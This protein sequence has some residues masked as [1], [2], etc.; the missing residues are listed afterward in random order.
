MCVEDEQ[1]GLTTSRP[2]W[3]SL[4]PQGSVCPSPT[5][6]TLLCPLPAC[7][8]LDTAGARQTQGKAGA[9]A[10]RV[11]G[12]D[13]QGR[14]CEGRLGNQ[15]PSFRGRADPAGAVREPG[16]G[17]ERGNPSQACLPCRGPEG[18][19]TH[20]CTQPHVCTRARTCP[21][22]PLRSASPGNASLRVPE[23]SPPAVPRLKLWRK[24][25]SVKVC[26]PSLSTSIASGPRLAGPGWAP[27]AAPHQ[28]P[29]L[30]G[31]M[32]W[33]CSPLPFLGTAAS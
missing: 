31:G 11:R 24:V 4:Q 14:L 6:A 5:Q 1:G 7:Q 30:C 28:P 10:P 16:G 33:G 22:A 3:T 9:G 29:L 12:S 13:S 19:C 18:P 21:H 23:Y 26:H 25:T 8:R 15:R 27:P 17:R 2:G 20:V 32:A